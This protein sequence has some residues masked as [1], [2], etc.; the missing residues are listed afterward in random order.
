MHLFDYQIWSKTTAIYPAKNSIE[1]CALGLCSEAGEVAGKVKKW[2]RDGQPLNE[3]KAEIGD[4]IWYLARLA[5]ECG[6]SLQ[7]IMEENQKKLQDRLNRNVISGNGD[8]R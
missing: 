7:E 5:D 3:V 2:I 6:W 8:A 4:C 1:Y